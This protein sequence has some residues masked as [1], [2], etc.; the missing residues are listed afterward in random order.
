MAS[1]AW[2]QGGRIVRGHRRM[3][4]SA[5]FVVGGAVLGGT[6]YDNAATAMLR[7]RRYRC[8]RRRKQGSGGRGGAGAAY[9]KEMRCDDDHD[10]VGGAEG[11]E[12][13][14]GPNAAVSESDAPEMVLEDDMDDIE[15]WEEM[16]EEDEEE[17]D[18]GADEE[19]TGFVSLRDR[20]KNIQMIPWEMLAQ[21]WEEEELYVHARTASLSTPRKRKREMQYSDGYDDID[22]F[23]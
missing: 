22:S 9:A 23:G 1:R 3:V 19:Q 12:D 17:E 10:K 7:R 20:I 13:G 6:A 14:I 16:E 5:A 21:E 2:R 18:A 11:R 15:D 4:R 8:T